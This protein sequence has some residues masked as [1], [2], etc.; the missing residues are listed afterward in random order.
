MRRM[1]WGID[2]ALRPCRARKRHRAGFWQFVATRCSGTAIATD[3]NFLN[4]SEQFIGLTARAHIPAIF[5]DRE[6]AARGGLLGYGASIADAHRLA[7]NYAGRILKGDKPSDL[8][9]QQSTRL[10]FVVVLRPPSQLACRY[11][12]AF[13]A[14]AD[15]VIE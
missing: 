14:I 7:G 6:F 4:W 10:E 3:A 9:V 8:P 12:R 13:L 11:H 15:E 5:H 2:V 1:C